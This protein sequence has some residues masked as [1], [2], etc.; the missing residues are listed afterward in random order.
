VKTILLVL[1]LGSL[2]TVLSVTVNFIDDPIPPPGV[3]YRGMPLAWL[4]ARPMLGP[5]SNW[6]LDRVWGAS[7]VRPL[8]FVI[9]SSFWAGLSY[10]VIVV[11]QRMRARTRE[12]ERRRR[13]LCV[14]CGYNLEGNTS[15]DCPECGTKFELGVGEPPR[16]SDGV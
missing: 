12:F 8:A 9:D 13:G 10:C 2:I 1:F 6:T 11:P 3:S 7:E 15:G 16:G 14:R 4:K 5:V